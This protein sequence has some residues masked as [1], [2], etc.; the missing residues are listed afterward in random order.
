M[1]VGYEVASGHYLTRHPGLPGDTSIIIRWKWLFERWGDL[2]E[3][4]GGERL[5]FGARLGKYCLQAKK[6][7]D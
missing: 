2:P 7:A 3:S 1:D 6:K 4:T 5:R